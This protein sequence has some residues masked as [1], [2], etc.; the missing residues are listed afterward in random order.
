MKIK[1]EDLRNMLNERLVEMTK[2]KG[3]DVHLYNG[4]WTQLGV[5]DLTGFDASLSSLITRT[6][7]R[8]AFNEIDYLE[9][10]EDSDN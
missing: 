9:V 10:I 6:G 7:I 3:V 5:N 1:K 2:D 8:I 4:H